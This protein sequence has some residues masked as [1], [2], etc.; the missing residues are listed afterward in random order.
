[1]PSS[2]FTEL[3]TL[4]RNAWVVDRKLTPSDWA[5]SYRILGDHASS[6]A[7]PWSNDRTPY[8]VG[9]MDEVLNE[10]LEALV[11]LKGAQ[12][13]F[14]ESMRNVLGFW[15]DSDPGPT[16]FVLP[17]EQAAREL[18]DERL[19]PF[20]QECQRLQA[21][22]TG[23]AED[24][25]LSSLRLSSMSVYMGW[26]GS[27]QAL[28]TRPIRY[29][30]CDEVDKYPAFSGREAD[31][32][33]LALK[34]VTTYGHRSRAIIGSS[35]TTRLGNIWRWWETCGEQLDFQVP[36]LHCKKYQRWTWPQ[37]R[38]PKAE[39]AEPRVGFADRV[40]MEGLAYYSCVHCGGRIKESDKHDALVQGRWVGLDQGVEAT[41]EIMG[42]RRS[43]R[44]IGM[45][46]PSFYSPWV[47]FSKLA[48]EFIRAEGDAGSTMDFRN[49]RLAEPFEELVSRL[50][51]SLIRGKADRAEAPGIVPPWAVALF[52]AADTQQDRFYYTVRAW[53]AGFRSQLVGHGVV[54][55]LGDL[56]A[57]TLDRE[58]LGTNGQK[59]QCGALLIDSGGNRT[60][61]IYQ[62]AQSDPERI[63]PTKGAG[64]TVKRPYTLSKIGDSGIYLRVLDVDYYK[65]LL[66]RLIT[67]D[68]NRW[69]PHSQVDDDYCSQMASE[70]KVLD[71][72]TRNFKWA[73]V[74]SGA[75]N[76]YWDCEVIQAAAADMVG[77][78][79]GGEPIN[80]EQAIVQEQQNTVQQ[81]TNDWRHRW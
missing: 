15:I 53:G 10:D 50:R 24:E 64:G 23:R 72:K 60:N 48:S 45:R 52:A 4:L 57:A 55:E 81:W 6:E 80:E 71:P 40:E 46:I 31:P 67:G 54:P 61:E 2:S 43:T 19:K 9:I 3:R 28:A 11:V 30:V 36:C 27:P 62:F 70:H 33:S 16:L 17:S 32:I 39:E 77:L 13:G 66:T 68:E 25:K 42:E 74:A 37:I 12:V 22:R 69:M 34:R 20:I 58:W 5:A 7:G 8:L 14:S 38:W 49:S 56:K 79:T 76:H 51:P 26:A 59:V 21:K 29:V 63:A 35:P 75:P 41:G 78:A 18:V 47:S 65:N 73:L 1:M 44:R